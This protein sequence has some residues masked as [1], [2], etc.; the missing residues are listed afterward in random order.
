[1]ESTPFQFV[2]HAASGA[3]RVKRCTRPGPRLSNRVMYPRMAHDHRDH[4]S[5]HLARGTAFQYSNQMNID[6]RRSVTR[7]NKP[8]ECCLQT[9]FVRAQ[10]ESPAAILGLPMIIINN[11]CF[12]VVINVHPTRPGPCQCPRETPER[13]YSWMDA[14]SPEEAQVQIN[15]TLQNG[16]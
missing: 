12:A 10:V 11:S 16:R 13:A 1:M 7:A 8:I 9:Q 2:M 6:S 4:P 3:E 5:I 14:H 15:S